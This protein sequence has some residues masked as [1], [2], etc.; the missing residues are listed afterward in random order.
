MTSPSDP[1]KDMIEVQPTEGEIVLNSHAETLYSHDFKNGAGKFINIITTDERGTPSEMELE[2]TPRLR[3]SLVFIKAKN[4][5][6]EISLKK[7]RFHKTRGWIEEKTEGIKLSNMTFKKLIGFLQFLSTIDPSLINERR[8]ALADAG[9]HNIDQETVKKIRTL[10]TRNDGPKII[11]ELLNS[12]LITSADIVNVGYRKKQ[13]EIFEKLLNDDAYFEIYRAENKINTSGNESIWQHFFETNNWI[14]GHG[15]NYVFNQS[16]DGQKLEQIIQGADVAQFGKRADGL[17]KT[18]GA[19]SSLCLV[20]IK[21]HK[22]PLLKIVANPYRQDCWQVSDELNGGVSQSQK[23]VQKTI[24]NTK[25]SPELRPKTEVGDPT[26]EIIY[27]YQPKSYLI[28]GNLN[29]FQS[30]HGI[31]REKFASFDLYRKNTLNPE[32]ITFDELHERAK[33]IVCRDEVV[34]NS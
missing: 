12:G 28:I 13:L 8:I 7:F 16:L 18:R 6:S 21:T 20:E 26:G 25:I 4:D 9:V 2:L 27:S 1:L 3:I 29:E 33:F 5:I 22:T 34:K 31:N 30:E 32:I 24:E 14:F 23:T 10:L 11:E 15:L 19:L 17:L